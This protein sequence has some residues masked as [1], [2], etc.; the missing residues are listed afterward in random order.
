MW[1]SLWVIQKTAFAFAVVFTFRHFMLGTGALMLSYISSVLRV[2]KLVSMMQTVSFLFDEN[3]CD[4]PR[5]RECGVLLL[6]F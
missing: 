6:L 3:M 5:W 2:L 1:G 4:V